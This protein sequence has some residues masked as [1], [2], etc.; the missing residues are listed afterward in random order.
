MKRLFL[1]VAT[2]CMP[3]LAQWYDFS[4][5][6]AA[7]NLYGA[8]NGKANWQSGTG[9][10]STQACT[11][12]RDHYFDTAGLNTYDCIGT[13][14]PGTWT[15][16]VTANGTF[17][18]PA[19]ITGLAWG[20]ITG[21][22]TFLQASNN[23][24]DLASAANARTSLG[25]GTAAVQNV[26][27]F[28]Q[29]A[30]NL[31][32]LA[33]AAN[34]RTN[35]GLGTFA[36]LN[37]PMTSPYDMIVGGAAGAPARLATPGVGTWCYSVPSSGPAS[38]IT[39]PGAG[40]GISSVGLALSS[41]AW[42]TL[43]NNPLTSNGNIGIAPTPGQ[44]PHQVIGTCG[45]ATIFGPCSLVAG[46]IPTLNQNTAGTAASVP[47]VIQSCTVGAGGVTANTLVMLDSSSGA[48]TCQVVEV[49]T[50]AT[51][52]YG[53]A[54]ATVGAAGSV[55]VQKVGFAQ[56]LL[57]NGTTTIG[58]IIAP[59]TTTAGYIHDSGNNSSN[60]VPIV[61]SVAS[62]RSACASA[63][64]G[65]L[66]WVELPGSDRGHQI[67]A[68][69]CSITTAAASFA[70]SET[71]CVGTP[72]GVAPFLN[73]EIALSNQSAITFSI[74]NWSRNNHSILLTQGGTTLTAVAW[75][76]GGIFPNAGP[77]LPYLGAETS[78]FGYYDGASYWVFAS[79]NGTGWSMPAT[80]TAPTCV[81]G[82]FPPAGYVLPWFDSTDLTLHQYDSACNEY[83][84][85]KYATASANEWVSYID[86]AGQHQTQPASTNLS[87]APNLVYITA[88]A[89]F[90]A[91]LYDFSAASLYVPGSAGG[92][93]G[94]AKCLLEDTTVGAYHNYTG[95]VDSMELTIPVASLGSYTNGDCA[96]ITKVGNL[97]RIGDATAPCGTS[98]GGSGTVSPFAQYDV[99]Y[100]T[101][102]GTTAQVGGVAINGI[103]FDSTTGPPAAATA[104]QVVAAEVGARPW[105][106]VSG[107]L[108]DGYNAIPAQT[109]LQNN[110]FNWTGQTVTLTGILCAVDNA[111]GSTSCNATDGSGNALLTGAITPSS[112][113]TYASGTQGSTTTIASGGFIKLTFVADGTTKQIS[114]AFKGTY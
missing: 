92:T 80:A 82:T 99:S 29:A 3:A 103:Q 65:T 53:V 79:P 4:T 70:I 112:A 47:A 114:M 81:S 61:D 107:G 59:S 101:Q 43:S 57:D 6:T 39:C 35:L 88:A 48:A 91:H 14:N 96:T 75:P 111:S 68:G 106:C 94:T 28:L 21:A 13:G 25:L 56:I 1:I 67:T 46:D 60:T 18:N 41:V 5:Q 84:Y 71:A 30:N 90:G 45:S 76:A 32:D 87:D 49:T 22:P 113:N 66:V 78:Y 62:V 85:V 100:Y 51:T 44:G 31:S 10:P 102:A 2:C 108:G 11:A 38:W 83:G 24:T 86:H 89:T 36:V 55:N 104:A 52:W 73:Y 64:A 37:N 9:A 97:V 34:A 77:P 23:L 8:M 109:Y 19:W 110:C 58:D 105:G 42:L 7:S 17:N 20:K 33:N 72:S 50:S 40:G 16:R 27:A 98:S 93:C 26:G 15:Q 12:G 63:C 74:S 54:L 69:T 95:G